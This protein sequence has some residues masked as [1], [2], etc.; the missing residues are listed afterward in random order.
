MP[1]IA[2]PSTGAS[3]TAQRARVRA[4]LNRF[5]RRANRALNIA[6]AAGAAI[7]FLAMVEIAYQVINGASAAISRYG[8]HF[9]VHGKWVPNVLNGHQPDLGAATFI[10]GTLVTS[11]TSLVLA[12]LIGVA[13]GLFLSM[14]APRRLAA[15]VGPLIEMLAAIPSVILGFCGIILIAP[16]AQSTLEPFLHSTL[17][18]IPLFGPPQPQGDSLFTASLV[19][20]IMV[21]PIIAALTR[22]LFLTV[23]RELTEGA[24]ALGATRWEVIRGVVLPTTTSGVIA[25]GVLGFGR[26]IGEAIAVAQVVG[27]IVGIHAS[28]FLGGATLASQIATQFPSPDNALHLSALYYLGAILLLFSVVTNLLSRRIAAGFRHSSA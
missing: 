7:L 12:M 22:D 18:F 23:P 16:F 24:E 28:L 17:G 2:R 6:C 21:V 13:I 4:R 20:T 19:L 26:A 25:A 27:G 3:P 8:P 10:Y 11:V 5:D 1:S 15:V 14:L 9:F